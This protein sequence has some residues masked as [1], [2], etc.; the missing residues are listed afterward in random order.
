MKIT[1]PI[2]RK[3]KQGTTLGQLYA[4]AIATNSSIELEYRPYRKQVYATILTEIEV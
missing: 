4:L 2:K 3:L 1:M